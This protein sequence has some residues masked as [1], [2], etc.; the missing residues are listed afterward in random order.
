MNKP[1]APCRSRLLPVAAIV[2]ISIR[3]STTFCLAAD[4]ELTT[5]PPYKTNFWRADWPSITLREPRVEAVADIS[6]ADDEL[7]FAVVLE[8]GFAPEYAGKPMGEVILA[9]LSAKE[10][11]TIYPVRFLSS[12]PDTV[13][14][15]TNQLYRLRYHVDSSL[16]PAGMTMRLEAATIYRKQLMEYFKANLLWSQSRLSEV[17][18]LLGTNLPAKLRKDVLLEQRLIPVNTIATNEDLVPHTPRLPREQQ[19]QLNVGVDMFAQR[20]REAITNT[21]TATNFPAEIRSEPCWTNIIQYIGE[22]FTRDTNDCGLSFLVNETATNGL[23]ALKTNESRMSFVVNAL[24]YRGLQSFRYLSGNAEQE[25][26]EKTGAKAKDFVFGGRIAGF[27]NFIANLE[28]L[29]Y[30]QVV[31]NLGQG[32][33]NHFSV[34]R[35]TFLNDSTNSVLLY[36]EQ[37][38]FLCRARLYSYHSSA[39]YF[40]LLEKVP[41]ESFTL[42]ATATGGTWHSKLRN[43]PEGEI[44]EQAE[45]ILLRPI[46]LNFMIR[47]YEDREFHTTKAAVYRTLDVAADITTALIPFGNAHSWGKDYANGAGIFSGIFVP[48]TKKLFGSATEVQKQTF[49]LESL[50]QYVEL[51]VGQSLS[52]LIYFPRHGYDKL[53]Q[54]RVLFISEFGKKQEMTIRAAILIK[55]KD[56]KRTP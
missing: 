55:P 52:K 26:E 37:I 49:L 43:S 33:A 7:A 27:T 22:H 6:I 35:V 28:Q 9:E 56:E 46:P 20:L 41:E 42:T 17:Y 11:G 30:K 19:N 23:E 39:S 51:E 44:T 50:P 29:P 54:D 12:S 10:T 25:G 18:T 36:G 45:P 40:R 14:A 32:I 24:M 1:A 38:R 8:P 4:K 13:R 31:S 53:V 21:P 3:L 16:I 5:P 48:A 34:F 47:G 15:G 2:S